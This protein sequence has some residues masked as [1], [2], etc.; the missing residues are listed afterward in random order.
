MIQEKIILQ[1]LAEQQE[2]IK[3]YKA[4]KWV[5][6]D[7]EAEKQAWLCGKSD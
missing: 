1:V 2:E 7:A 6:R 5:P 4:Q 3:G